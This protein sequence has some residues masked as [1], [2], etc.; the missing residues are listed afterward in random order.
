MPNEDA[1]AKRLITRR[2]YLPKGIIKNCNVIINGKK[3]HTQTIDS[4]IK[5]Y[6]EVRIL[7]TGKDQDS[8]TGC[9]LD[10]DYI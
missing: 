9:I 6:E 10:Y 2:Y 4:N 1:N 5:Q 8:T 7:S 3:N